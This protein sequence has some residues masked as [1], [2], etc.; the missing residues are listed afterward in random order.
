MAKKIKDNYDEAFAQAFAARI[1][2]VLPGF[3]SGCFLRTLAGQLDGKELF[4]RLDLFALALARSLPG[5]YPQQIAALHPLLGPELPTEKGMYDT[6][7]WLWPL[8]RYVEKHG[9]E[10]FTVSMAFIREL[11]KRFTGEFAI[12]PLLAAFP[13]ATM[14]EMV[15]W[16]RDD[17]VHIRRLASEG[18]RIRLPWA[19]KL[20][21]ALDRFDEY[22]TILARLKDDPSRFVQRSVGNNLND[23]YKEA[24]ALADGIVA[25]W[26]A[27]GP[28]SEAARWTLRHGRRNLNRGG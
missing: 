5:R 2:V 22:R 1:V 9:T 7:G 14:A 28:L 18:V 23:L 27:D 4:A 8:A 21:V 25:Q 11:T 13:A 15:A 6:G 12:R 17:N 19:K 24:P 20:T 10:D 3:A 16:S 26:E